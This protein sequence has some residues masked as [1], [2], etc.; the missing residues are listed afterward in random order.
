MTASG[1]NAISGP[2]RRPPAREKLLGGIRASEAIE[3]I[4]R[5]PQEI[6][7]VIAAARR[8]RCLALVFGLS[9][10]LVTPW[11]TEGER[12][13]LGGVADSTC[14]G[15]VERQLMSIQEQAKR[16]AS[17]AWPEPGVGLTYVRRVRGGYWPEARPIEDFSRYAEIQGY[18]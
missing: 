11:L 14:A 5:L 9:S 13:F 4:R 18:A 8:V 16:R 6:S 17:T 3:A 10:P 12:E 2:Q 1:A 15:A 7:E